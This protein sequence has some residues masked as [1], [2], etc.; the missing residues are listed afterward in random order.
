MTHSGRHL[1]PRTPSARTL[2]VAGAITASALTASACALPLGAHAG[3]SQTRSSVTPAGRIA[4]TDQSALSQTSG[5]LGGG[6]P[7]AYNPFTNADPTAGAI[8]G[9]H[10]S[11][12]PGVTGGP[13]RPNAGTVNSGPDNPANQVFGGYAPGSPYV[14]QTPANPDPSSYQTVGHTTNN[15]PCPVVGHAHSC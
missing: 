12:N 4:Q 10:P 9:G 5:Q 13:V 11:S 7:S 8:G 15:W 6:H 3:R 2:A 14:G 1:A